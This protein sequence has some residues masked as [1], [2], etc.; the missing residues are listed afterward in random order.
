M[1]PNSTNARQNIENFASR[2]RP[3]RAPIRNLRV[4]SSRN[5]VSILNLFDKMRFHEQ[6]RWGHPDGGTKVHPGPA[7]PNSVYYRRISES[8]Y[9]GMWLL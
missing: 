1:T 8:P 5:Q 6:L 4:E 9:G 3:T 2:V 7:K